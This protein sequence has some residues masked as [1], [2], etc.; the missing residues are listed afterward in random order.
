MMCVCVYDIYAVLATTLLE[1][2][3]R[4]AAYRKSQQEEAANSEGSS[5]KCLIYI[6]SR[7]YT[8]EYYTITGSHPGANKRMVQTQNGN[9]K[10]VGKKLVGAVL[11]C[12]KS[13]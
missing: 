6:Q 9:W 12:I 4:G 5:D 10:L 8:I 3:L 11:S 1:P 7:S 2:S 13:Q